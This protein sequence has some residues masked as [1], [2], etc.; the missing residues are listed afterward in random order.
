MQPANTS[1]P[2]VLIDYFLMPRPRPFAQQAGMQF[3]HQV[4]AQR[5]K[6]VT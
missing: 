6:V 3:V 4:I 1:Q 2:V 5:V